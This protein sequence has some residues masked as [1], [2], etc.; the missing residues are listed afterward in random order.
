M[1]TPWGNSDNVVSIG[2]NAYWVET[3]SHGGIMVASDTAQFTLSEKARKIAERFGRWYCFEEDCNWAAFAYERPEAMLGMT[4]HETVDEI[5][6]SARECLETWH[7]G[8][9]GLPGCEYDDGSGRLCGSRLEEG[10]QFCWLHARGVVS[11]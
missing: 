6:A 9:F 8:Y 1:K 10:S 4:S 11:Q 2:A 3:P 5:K 7:P